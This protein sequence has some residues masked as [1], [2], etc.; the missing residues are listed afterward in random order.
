MS[1]DRQ[2]CGT[3]R[4]WHQHGQA[5]CLVCQQDTAVQYIDDA[6]ILERFRQRRLADKTKL[7]VRA[8]KTPARDEF[9]M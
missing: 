1:L 8:L 3:C 4:Y 5:L 2:R 9:H 7:A 6:A